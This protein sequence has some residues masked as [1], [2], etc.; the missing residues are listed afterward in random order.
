MPIPKPTSGESEKDFVSR[1][2]SKIIDEYDQSQAAA[3]CY[4]SYR[5][6]EEMKKQDELF[7]LQPKKTEN[8]GMYLSRCSNNAKMRRQFPQMKERLGFCLTS[9]N[10]YYKYWTKIEMAEVPKESALGLC[11]AKQKSKGFDYREAYA[12]CASQV[13][14]KPLGSGQSINLNEDLLIEPVEFAEMDVLGYETKYF[15]LCPGAQA[16][17]E[18]LIEMPLEEEYRGMIRTAAQVADNVFEIEADVLENEMATEKQLNMAIMLV[19]DFK[20]IIGEINEESG[21][22]HDVSF[23]DGHINKIKE[24]LTTE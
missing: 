6:K 17:F 15:Y 21:M 2:I 7:V 13:G 3:I 20:D 19:Q 22:I 9:F 5:K 8:R 4:E 1:C 24:Y 10:E 11:I 16:L 18:H 14:I 23:M 12:R